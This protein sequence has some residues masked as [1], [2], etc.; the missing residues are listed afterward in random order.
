MHKFRFCGIGSEGICGK[1]NDMNAENIIYAWALNAGE[2]TFPEE[3]GLR[4]GGDTDIQYLV[5]QMHYKDSGIVD[6]SG[7]SIRITNEE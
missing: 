7:L 3:T 2:L 5:L 4:I 6:N 1:E